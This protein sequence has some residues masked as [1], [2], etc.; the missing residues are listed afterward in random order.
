MSYT[1]NKTDGSTDI[2]GLSGGTLADGTRHLISDNGTY[3]I[4][5]IG[6]NSTNFGDAMNENFVHL[7][8]NFSNSVE[9]QRPLVGQLW[10]NS[11]ENVMRVRTA[12]NG[13]ENWSSI[14]G[15]TVI[16]SRSALPGS[17]TTGSLWYTDDTD[18]LF[19]Y[20]GAD[21]DK[22]GQD[23]ENGL[24]N[25]T[26]EDTN[27][28][29]HS[30]LVVKIG[31]TTTA[32]FSNSDEFTPDA[33]IAGFTTIKK[34]W[35]I[36]DTAKYNGTVENSEQLG[37]IDADNYLRSDEAD[38][39]AGKFTANSDDGIDVGAPNST[40]TGNLPNLRIYTDGN[41]GHI[42][43]RTVDGN[44]YLGINDGGNLKDVITIDGSSGNTTFTGQLNVDSLSVTGGLT[45]TGNAALPA[46]EQ[47]I[48][49]DNSNGAAGAGPNF[50]LTFVDGQSGNH[51]VYTD[52]ALTYNP[53]TNILNTTVT[54]VRINA[55]N[56][57]DERV[58]LTFVDGATGAQ[59]LE[60]DTGLYYSPRDNV[61]STTSTMA[62]YADLAEK[63]STDSEYISG[64]IM[65]INKKDNS[66]L[67]IHSDSFSPVIGVVSTK[68]AYL[69]NSKAEGQKIALVGRVPIRVAGMVNKGDILHVDS[70]DDGVAS[71]DGN[72]PSVGIAL[73]SNDLIEEK[74]VE[75][76]LHL[77][78]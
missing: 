71:I 14:S 60:T 57:N 15:V 48:I 10:F 17:P 77:N 74:L 41:H 9:P 59:G 62:Q 70:Y 24:T 39:I 28:T 6:R 69:M 42:K 34:G 76:Y 64:T 31:G 58:Y 13:V 12:I 75:C 73:E 53:S 38:S 45:L 25:D 8:E 35:N 46:S 33:A 26:I 43:N 23:S 44:L 56:N 18:E 30:V 29:S 19:I 32:V 3:G 1:I 63:Y 66:E 2:P 5:L 67:T 65:M 7:L 68:P 40:N 36:L 52:D 50:Y 37:G 21:L 4:T 51:D 61:L 27:G 11:T 78:K 49:K 22:V 54:N 47:I 72:G 20:N 16:S 55:N